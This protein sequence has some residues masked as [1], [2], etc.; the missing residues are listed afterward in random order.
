MRAA[1][2][3]VPDETA[4]LDEVADDRRSSSL[5]ALVLYVVFVLFPIVQA[6][7][8][9]LYKWNGL[10]P[11]DDFVGLKNYQ[12]ALA[13]DVFWTAVMQQRAGHRP[14]APRSR[15]RSRWR[16]PS[17]SIGGS[18][19]APSS[20]CCSSCRTSCPRPSPASSSGSSSSPDA[21][22]DAS[23][24]TRRPRRT[25]S[26]TGWATR[27]IVMFTLFVIISW[28]YFGF[29]MIL[30]LA[31]LQGIPHEIEEAAL[32]DGAGRW[33]VVPLRDPAAARADP[34]RLDL[35]VDDRRPAAVRHGLGDD[36]RRAAQRVARRWPSTCSR[37]ASRASRWATAAPWR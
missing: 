20:G 25:S 28:K 31:G 16:W 35:P 21:L 5:P 6:A 22:V 10:G 32:I 1:R 7:H 11:L 8:F 9:S 24:S 23:L 34:A 13:S 27:T 29:H 2:T 33:Q 3:V 18:G 12:V 4:A 14:V 37:P 17:C 15:S 19:V 36:R 30:L 26:R